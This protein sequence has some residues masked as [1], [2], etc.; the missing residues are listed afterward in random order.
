MT[1]L[2]IEQ[3]NFIT[4]I[5]RNLV[6]FSLIAII[7]HIGTT[8]RSGHYTATIVSNGK[9]YTCND[10]RISVKDSFES[11]GAYMVFYKLVS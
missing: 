8:I 1:S 2:S 9:F 5:G 10:D 11:E 4:N 3:R 6:L 7:H